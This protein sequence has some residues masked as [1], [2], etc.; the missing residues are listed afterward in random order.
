M[1]YGV[2]AGSK[3]SH[4]DIRDIAA[5]EVKTLTKDGHEGK[6]YRLKGPVTLYSAYVLGSSRAW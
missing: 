2:Q 4:I 1:R 3:I 6:A 5:V